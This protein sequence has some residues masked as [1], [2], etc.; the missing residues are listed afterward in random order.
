MSLETT[1]YRPLDMP[2]TLEGKEIPWRNAYEPIDDSIAA[3]MQ[4]QADEINELLNSINFLPEELDD[5]KEDINLEWKNEIV[6]KIENIKNIIKQAKN[7]SADEYRGMRIDFD[8]ELIESKLN[9]NLSETERNQIETECEKCLKQAEVEHILSEKEQERN[10][11]YEENNKWKTFLESQ[12]NDYNKFLKENENWYLEPELAI[13]NLDIKTAEASLKMINENLYIMPNELELER[14]DKQKQDNKTELNRLIEE[15]KEVKKRFASRKRAS[16]KGYTRDK[17]NEISRL[18]WSSPSKFDLLIENSNKKIKALIGSIEAELD[19]ASKSN[20]KE[21]IISAHK[22]ASIMKTALIKENTQIRIYWHEEWNE[23]EDLMV[24]IMEAKNKEETETLSQTQEVYQEPTIEE[25][26]TPE[27]ISRIVEEPVALDP[28]M[29]EINDEQELQ[30]KSEMN[31]MSIIEAM[32][33]DIKSNP[34]KDFD[35]NRITTAS[36]YYDSIKQELSTVEQAT[37]ETLL[38]K[39]EKQIDNVDLQNI[40]SLDKQNIDKTNYTDIIE[41]MCNDIKENPI[42]DVDKNRITTATIYYDS[43]KTELSVVEQATMEFLIEETDLLIDNLNKEKMSNNN[44]AESKNTNNEDLIA[45]LQAAYKNPT[46]PAYDEFLNNL[47]NNKNTLTE[48]QRKYFQDELKKLDIA[49]GEGLDQLNNQH[50]ESF[51]R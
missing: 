34:T 19:L 38:E 40:E 45:T 7:N 10:K 47:E 51:T 46:S 49:R 16:L 5:Q 23:K 2:E 1:R 33:N 3:A 35:K 39:T 36:I 29:P 14:R 22:R 4:R 9:G 31:Y 21:D 11:A 13:I 18:A 41:A 27:I 37:I 20:S 24:S 48:E 6:N 42:K 32:C 17:Q 8:I 28:S 12:I 50:N 15:E 43:I 25:I 44:S 30:N 26:V